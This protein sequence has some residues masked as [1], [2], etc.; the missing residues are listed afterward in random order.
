LDSVS[1]L[2]VA[3]KY[4]R[5]QVK[6]KLIMAYSQDRMT[7]GPDDNSLPWSCPADLARFRQL[8]LDQAILMGRKT[9]ESLPGLLPRRLHLVLARSDPRKSGTSEDPGSPGV[10]GWN[11][12]TGHPNLIWVTS[13]DEAIHWTWL[14]TPPGTSLWF[15]G[16]VSSLPLVWRYLSELHLHQID[17]GLLTVSPSLL[18]LPFP[19]VP[20]TFVLQE[21]IT[22][23]G[24]ITGTTD[25]N[26]PGHPG[27][28]GYTYQVYS[29]RQSIPG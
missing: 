14:L 11:L 28:P 22:S 2:E 20:E 21:P 13:I 18:R 3:N 1:D 26:H 24:D 6:V 23:S 17:P 15:I 16:G 12:K 19:E 5:Q 29:A 9:F 27:H 10:I 7:A 25:K 8:T 4:L